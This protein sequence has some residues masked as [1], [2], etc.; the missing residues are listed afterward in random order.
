MQPQA[1]CTISEELTEADFIAIRRAASFTFYEFFDELHNLASAN[2]YYSALKK[3][4]EDRD[5]YLARSTYYTGNYYKDDFPSSR[6]TG[7]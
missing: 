2:F 6:S 7:I 4:K 1:L 5:T 3:A